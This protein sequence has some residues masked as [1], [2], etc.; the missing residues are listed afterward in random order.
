V[1]TPRE[2]ETSEVA[3][4]GEAEATPGKP[5]AAKP[6]LAPKVAKMAESR[7]ADGYA[8]GAKPMQRSASFIQQ[9]TDASE[10]VMPYV[11]PLMRMLTPRR[12][13][14]EAEAELAQ[15]A[16][17]AANHDD[18]EMK[19][20][21]DDHLTEAREATS[22]T[23]GF[24]L[25]LA[26]VATY[27]EE[28]AKEAAAATLEVAQAPA[29]EITAAVSEASAQPKGVRKAIAGLFRALN[30][31]KHAVVGVAVAVAVGVIVGRAASDK[32]SRR[33]K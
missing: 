26:K 32:V 12:M 17:D 23:P 15:A 11:R 29:A 28:E 25:D 14:T 10:A 19:D 20:L 3:V 2:E 16:E 6:P 30:Q 24:R 33:R 18:A 27:A 21:E 13:A 8:D 31:K 22:T 9:L 7:E 5:E 4:D 1:P